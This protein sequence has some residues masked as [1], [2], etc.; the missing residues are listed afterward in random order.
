VWYHEAGA[1]DDAKC[2]S[3]SHGAIIRVFDQSGAVIERHEYASDF[4]EWERGL[5]TVLIYPASLM[6]N[7]AAQF[8]LGARFPEVISRQKVCGMI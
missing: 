6:P 2:Y 8:L 3:R 1:V 7:H 5:A 4:K